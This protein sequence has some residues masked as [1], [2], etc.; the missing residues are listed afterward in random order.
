[1]QNYLAT[2]HDGEAEWGIDVGAR[3]TGHEVMRDVA[4]RGAAVAVSSTGSFELA[5]LGGRVL[6]S[7]QG[8]PLAQPSGTQFRPGEIDPKE[9]S[10]ASAKVGTSWGNA[11]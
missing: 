1:M 10:A 6:N 4:G 7:S 8:P 2:D 5:G 9:M 3:E 11:E